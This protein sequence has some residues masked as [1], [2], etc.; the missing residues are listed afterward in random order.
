ER[1][2]RQIQKIESSGNISLGRKQ[3]K[4]NDHFGSALENAKALLPENI[5]VSGTVSD[6]E[7]NPLIGVNIQ[8]KGTTK[9]TSTD[10]DGNFTLEDVD[11]N[12]VLVISY[13]GYQTQEVE[14]SGK[15]NL[16]ITLTSDSQLLDEVV[17]VGYG[18]RERGQL[19]GSVS[20]I[21]GEDLQRSPSVNLASSLQGLLPG[22]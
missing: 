18:T 10:F 12:A 11:E 19:T 6:E 20:S 16:S 2:M 9:G 7:G 22:T 4:V 17:V 3:A 14:V 1:K 8:V 21:Q 15:S 13:I 5:D